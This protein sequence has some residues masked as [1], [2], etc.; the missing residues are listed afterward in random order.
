MSSEQ[1]IRLDP[2]TLEFVAS[3]IRRSMQAAHSLGV[4]HDDPLYTCLKS[5]AREAEQLAEQERQRAP[6]A[7]SWLRACVDS[8]MR[9]RSIDLIMQRCDV[10]LIDVDSNDTLAI[11]KTTVPSKVGAGYAYGEHEVRI[12]TPAE[13]MMALVHLA[14][15][16]AQDTKVLALGTHAG[17]KDPNA[18]I[19]YPMSA[20]V[21]ACEGTGLGV[22]N[23]RQGGSNDHYTWFTVTYDVMKQFTPKGDHNAAFCIPTKAGME[24]RGYAAGW[25]KK[26]L[27]VHRDCSTPDALHEALLVLASRI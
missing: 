11:L 20:W 25:T 16:T 19:A 5:M 12:T 3:M 27:W 1:G 26:P 10:V 18:Q 6:G 14:P 23:I 15:S 17:D 2:K 24:T 22:P 13:L 9:I 8:G 4:G 21:R 7:M